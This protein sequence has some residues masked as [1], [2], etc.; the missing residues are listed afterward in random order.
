MVFSF[1]EVVINL[2]QL[3]SMDSETVLTKLGGRAMLMYDEK[4]DNCNWV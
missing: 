2:S 3:D 1:K 4:H